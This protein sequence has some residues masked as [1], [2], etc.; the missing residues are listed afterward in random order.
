MLLAPVRLLGRN[1]LEILS[2]IGGMSILFCQIIAESRS[3]IRD[4]F[5]V[6]EQMQLVG[7]R[8]LPLVFITSLFTGAVS[9]WQA[10]YQ[11][12]GFVSMT[13]LGGATSLAI[14]I[15]LGPV[16]TAFVMAGRIGSSIAAELGT[17]KVT[18][19]IDALETLAISPIRY[20]AMPRFWAA[21]FMLPL[22][23]IFAD[24]IG[25][26]GAYIVANN[27]LDISTNMFFDSV[28]YFFDLR[29]IFGGLAKAFAF[30]AT[31]AIVGCFVGL[32]TYGGAEG[33]GRSTIEAFVLSAAL[34]LIDDYILATLI[35]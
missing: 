34:I 17:M 7:V 13:Y 21:F 18:E 9:S 10:A 1:I 26:A 20:L 25:I 4:R 32:R 35:F 29:N 33:V 15:E 23:T 14:F 3:I 24:F 28:K 6:I 22:L 11:F 16:L 31:I 12:E 30:G 2:N 8:S 27:L 5:L 19:Q